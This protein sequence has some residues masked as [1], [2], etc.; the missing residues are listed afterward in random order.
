M[1][2]ITPSESVWERIDKRD[3]VGV[4]ASLRSVLAPA[5]IAIVG[6]SAAPDDPGA[7]VSSNVVDGHFQGVAVPINRAGGGI[8]SIRVAPSIAELED[9]PELVVT[10]PPRRSSWR[11]LRGGGKGGEGACPTPVRNGG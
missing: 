7:A 10:R 5:S 9:A 1:L 4:V 6:A 11:S 8:R 3:H 2:D